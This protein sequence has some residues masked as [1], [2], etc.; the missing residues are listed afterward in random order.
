MIIKGRQVSKALKEVSEAIVKHNKDQWLKI[1]L[2][3]ELKKIPTYLERWFAMTNKIAF[4]VDCLARDRVLSLEVIS[5]I[6]SS[7]TA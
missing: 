6:A 7:Y 1:F 4:V 5:I 2:Q 3:L